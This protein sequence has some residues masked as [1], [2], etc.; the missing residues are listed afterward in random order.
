MLCGMMK[1]RYSGRLGCQGVDPKGYKAAIGDNGRPK[2]TAEGSIT[3][4]VQEFNRV[5]RKCPKSLLLFSG[6]SQGAA[7]MHNAIPLLGA[8]VKR[9]IIGGALFGDTRN[10]QTNASVQGLPKGVGLVICAKTD[11][12]CWGGAPTN[13]HLVY[14]QN[15]DVN[16]AANF[17]SKKV[18]AALGRRR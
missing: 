12:V 11:G 6:Y 18:D 7:V 1:K 4:A 3:A 9:Q 14:T 8:D 5:H 16:S 13:G 15:G 10:K 17:L 2:G